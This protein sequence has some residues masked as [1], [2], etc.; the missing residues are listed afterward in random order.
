MYSK[1]VIFD[2]DGV[3]V[4]SEPI[5]NRIFG[6]MLQEIGLPLT[7]QEVFDRFVGRSMSYCYALIESLLG[8]PLPAGFADAYISRCNL[9][10]ARELKPVPHIELVLDELARRE[11]PYCVASSGTHDK[12]RTTLGLTGLLHRFEG[13]RYST[14]EVAHAKPAPDVYLYAAD[15][16]GVRPGSCCVV[17]DT[18]VGVSAALSAGMTVYGYC[19]RTPQQVLIG[20]GAHHTVSDMRE[21]P[22]LL[23]P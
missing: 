17:E 21:L 2:C 18:A 14:T 8:A 13:R 12:M 10:L 15:K 11:V 3:L 19:G 9:A 4:D 16:Q 5:T 22:Q 1:L 20:A 6:D 7:Q 23:F